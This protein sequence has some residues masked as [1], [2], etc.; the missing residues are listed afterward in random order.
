MVFILGNEV[1][2]LFSA[3]YDIQ[4]CLRCCGRCHHSL[5][6]ISLRDIPTSV[7]CIDALT[8]LM[9][10][11]LGSMEVVMDFAQVQRDIIHTSGGMRG[12]LDAGGAWRD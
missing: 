4:S 1:F 3:V 5:L 7:L 12:M 8:L 6:L 2:S 11:L 9:M 10:N